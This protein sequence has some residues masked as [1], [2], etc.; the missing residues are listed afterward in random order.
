MEMPTEAFSPLTRFFVVGA[1][2]V[3]VLL[4]MRATASILN[5]F[6]LALMVYLG[7][8]PAQAWLITRGVPGWLSLL[9]VL[10]TL[11]VG[12][13]L[14][15]VV[16]AVSAVHLSEELPQYE[17]R[18]EAL[19]VELRDWLGERGIDA[20]E[21][22]DLKLYDPRKLL[23]TAASLV[24]QIANV[25]GWAASFLL[26]LAFMLAYGRDFVPKLIN[27]F[28]KDSAAIKRGREYVSDVGHYVAITTLMGLAAAVGDVILLWVTGVDFALFF[29][30]LSFI[31]S[32]IPNVGFVLALLPPVLL[33]LLQFGPYQALMVLAGYYLI[34][35]ISDQ[36]IKPKVMGRGVNLSG[37]IITLSLFLWGWVLGPVGTILAVPLTL[38]FKTLILEATDETQWIAEAMGS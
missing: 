25:V 13:A 2:V 23:D 32:F 14:L 37:L 3:I 29:G 19:K 31:M 5:P 1:A 7:A 10:L 34:N 38:T 17:P 8:A 22:L 26:I 4:G 33:A 18:V 21:T 20:G 28:G 12:L 30:A 36:V 35:G 9:I 16:M 27:R 11:V 15:M 24:D 6:F